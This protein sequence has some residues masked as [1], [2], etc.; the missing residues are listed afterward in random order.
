MSKIDV[1]KNNNQL[2]HIKSLDQLLKNYKFSKTADIT[3]P[4]HVRIGN[5]QLKIFGGSYYLDISNK[6]LMNKFFITNTIPEKTLELR[7]ELLKEE[8]SQHASKFE[9]LSIRDVVMQLI[10]DNFKCRNSI[11]IYINNKNYSNFI[12]DMES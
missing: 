3:R 1:K 12:K 8:F 4:N 9:I 10:C 6:K 7:N 5:A 2:T 11:E